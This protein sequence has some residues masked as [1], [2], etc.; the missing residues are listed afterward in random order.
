[1]YNNR[2]V[3]V[4]QP[5]G[6]SICFTCTAVFKREEADHLNL[7]ERVDLSEKYGAVLKGKKPE[8]H[9]ECPGVDS[10]W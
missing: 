1:M 7:Q 8:D 6:K 4:T 9:E 2:T 5:E 3:E 10:P